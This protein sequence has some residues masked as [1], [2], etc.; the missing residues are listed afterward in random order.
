MSCR[1][2]KAQI[3]PPQHTAKP[4][5]SVTRIISCHTDH[6]EIYASHQT[7]A[8]DYVLILLKPVPAILHSTILSHC[9]SWVCACCCLNFIAIIGRVLLHTFRSISGPALFPSLPIL[10]PDA[11]LPARVSVAAFTGTRGDARW[12]EDEDGGVITGSPR[13]QQSLLFLGF[14]SFSD[15]TLLFLV[16]HSAGQV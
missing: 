9:D 6:I 2:L 5:H 1:R 14:R 10:V 12:G 11:F 15:L 13:C 8:G 16:L 7:H 4:I 3:K